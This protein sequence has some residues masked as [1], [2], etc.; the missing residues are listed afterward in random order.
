MVTTSFPRA[1]QDDRGTFVWEA[2]RGVRQH[3]ALVRV[4]AIHSPGSKTRESMDGVEVIRPRYLWPERLEQLQTE[5]GGLP[6]VL[7]KYPWAWLA[8]PPFFTAQLI[9]TARFA[10]GY[11]LIHAHWTLSAA[12]AWLSR[13]AHRCPIV[14]TV[15]GSDI[16]QAG[17]MPIIANLTKGVLA[18]CARVLCLSHSLAAATMA[19]GVPADKIVIMPN[20]VDTDRFTPP[21]QPREAL[22]ISVGSLIER[23]GMKYLIQAMPRVCAQLPDYRLVIIGEGPQRAELIALAESLGVASKVQ[24][25]G[26]QP[27]AQIIEWMKRAQLF[28]LP[29]LEEALGQV[30]LEALATGTPCVATNIG[31]IPDAVSA[32]VG[33]LVPPADPITLADAM[34]NILN[35]TVRWQVFSTQARVRVVENFSTHKI[36]AGLMDVYRQVLE[37]HQTTRP[38]AGK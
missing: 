25:V 15:Q 17:K 27:H 34:V 37:E 33:V 20:G 14:L 3:G 22:I 12:A 28:V 11:D 19:L 7:R 4:V 18:Q 23:K 26:I 10:R 36:A 35:D 29:S 38:K 24:L 31:G 21:Q 9:A 13:A 8:V 5:G 1:P 16:F 32:D 6:I 2:V 30:L